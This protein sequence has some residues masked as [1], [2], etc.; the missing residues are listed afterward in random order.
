MKEIVILGAGNVA[1]HLT[2]AL[3]NSGYNI[4]QVYSRNLSNA[5]CLAM[6]VGA[7]PV[8][9]IKNLY[10][11]ADF[12]LIAVSDAAISTVAESMPRVLGIVAHTA[13][14]VNLATLERF[15]RHGVL[16]PFQTFTK[17]RGI[18]FL[19]IPVLIEG[20]RSDVKRALVELASGISNNV[21]KADSQ[22][23][24]IL[25][26]A[27]VFSSNFVNHMYAISQTLLDASGLDFN[28]L[29]PLISET[30][31]KALTMNPVDAQTGPARRKD[32][33]VMGEHVERLDSQKLYQDIYQLVSK[34]IVNTYHP[35]S[36]FFS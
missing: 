8:C 33:G 16:Y 27:A 21:Q 31:Q 1:T 2:V 4:K 9:D 29:K 24:A 23:R 20:N 18:D 13:G 10:R 26:V 12:Y 15:E 36:P 3:K 11:D 19:N 14:S 30:T 25:H 7:E 5:D 34:S 17:D 6:L 35:G 32:F 28:L 22:K